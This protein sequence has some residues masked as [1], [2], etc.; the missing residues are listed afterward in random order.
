MLLNGKGIYY[1]IE[2]LMML[3]H[4]VQLLGILFAIKL[5]N[6]IKFNLI[7][8]YYTYLLSFFL[9]VIICVKNRKNKILFF[10]ILC[11]FTKH[12]KTCTNIIIF[13][14]KWVRTL[15]QREVQVL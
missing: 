14:I 5:Y 8:K 7:S 12:Y 3:G 13:N 11:L 9:V 4:F 2:V 1:F 10:Y 15:S 6:K